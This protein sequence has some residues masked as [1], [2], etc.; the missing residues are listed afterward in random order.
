[1]MK[2]D[3]NIKSKMEETQEVTSEAGTEPK[4]PVKGFPDIKEFLVN[5]GDDQE[6]V[7]EK[8]II[9]VQAKKPNSQQ[10]IR[11]HPTMEQMVDVIK[12]KD[13]KDELYLLHPKITPYLLEQRQRV[14]LYL[15]I[16]RSGSPFLFPVPQP[17]KNGKS[18]SWHR[19][20]AEAI[21]KARKQWVRLQPD[22]SSGGYVLYEAKGKIP[23]PEWPTD[24]SMVDYISIAFK[25]K[26]IADLEH[27]IIKALEGQ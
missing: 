3:K 26:M 5:P 15:C 2:K 17:D 20:A 12:W 8:K 24:M 18:Y 9:T 7:I 23:D 6:I 10:F 1:M 13:D 19:S 14:M 21:L 16:H 11:A 4:K 27:P 22:N 25:D